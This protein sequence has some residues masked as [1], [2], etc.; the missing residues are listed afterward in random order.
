MHLVANFN[1][2]S[3]KNKSLYFQLW[4]VCAVCLVTRQVFGQEIQD[5]RHKSLSGKITDTQT[6]APVPGVTVYITDLKTGGISDARGN[7]LISQLPA[8]SIMVRVSCIGYR[9]IIE[10]V[11]LRVTDTL[12]F[13]VSESVAEIGEVVVTGLSTASELQ[14]TTS[15]VTTVP[16]IKL[17]ESVA[18]NVIDALSLTP[19][20]SQV[21]T[22]PSVS[23]PVIRGL[24]YNR[25]VVVN[26]G[27]RQE[28]QQ[29][30]DEHGIELDEYAVGEVEI[31]KGPASLSYGSDAL[32]GVM[33]FL[34]QPVLPEGSLQAELLLNYQTNHGL[35]GTSANTSGNLDGNVWDIRISRK[36]A[37]DYQNKYDGYVFNTR[38]RELAATGM[39]GINRSWGYTHLHMGWYRLEPGIA[40]GE[41]DSLTGEFVKAEAETDST[42]TYSLVPSGELKSYTPG[43]PR[44]QIDHFKAVL[45]THLIAG[46]GSVKAIAGWQQNI[47][48]EFDDVNSPDEFGLRFDLNTFNYDVRYLLPERRGMNISFGA[49]G[50]AQSSENKGTEFLIPAYHLFDAGVFAIVTQ[51][52]NR[53][54]ISGGFRYDLRKQ[55]AES[56]FLSSE[57]IPVSGETAG[58][59]VKFAGFDRSFEGWS[60]SAG[61]TMQIND[62]FFTKLNFARGWRAPNIAELGS[63][64]EHE[65][66]GRYEYGNS[67]L[68][69][70][71]IVQGDFTIGCRTDHVNGEISLFSNMINDYIYVSKMAAFNGSDSLV[72]GIPV[73]EYQSGNASLWGGEMSFDIHPHPLDWLHFE[74]TFSMVAGELKNQPDSSKYLPFIPAPKLVSE[75]KAR[76]KKLGSFMENAYVGVGIVYQA[77]QDKVYLVNGTETPTDAYL[78]IHAGAGTDIV[79]KKRKIASFYL[80]ATNLTDAAYQDHLSRLKYAPENYK[81]GRTGIFG[82]GRNVSFRMIFPF[83][84]RQSW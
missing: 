2:M 40:E 24:G 52:L 47:R 29:W 23:K 43:I 83:S 3:R 42:S 80:G 64:G 26:N 79:I 50:M 70:E 75:L 39:A 11:D 32:A 31:L 22:G 5:T 46:K 20:V 63:N 82:T 34:S 51:S 55:K 58:A 68:D 14:R 17:R 67:S 25:V 59:T 44:Q 71:Q 41:R 35:I 6:G 48:R 37:H 61:V 16:G 9:T 62:D 1:S 60:G 28:G 56:L 53:F 10:T 66:T 57:G 19:G 13:V 77:R 73:F 78:L 33:H 84:W 38:F 8:R 12:D 49:N 18:N 30:G 36:S 81:T 7:Y 72:D 21:T 27:V 65:G 54:D 69:P 74:T 4:M 76:K 45:N 15:P